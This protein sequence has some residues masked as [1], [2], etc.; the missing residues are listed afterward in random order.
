MEEDSCSY[1]FFK[2]AHFYV[3]YLPLNM[4]TSVC[5]YVSIILCEYCNDC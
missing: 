4:W 3:Q 5:I 1:T 2:H